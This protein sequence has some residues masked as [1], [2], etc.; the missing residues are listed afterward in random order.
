MRREAM[1][2]FSEDA[3]QVYSMVDVPRKAGLDLVGWSRPTSHLPFLLGQVTVGTSVAL[4]LAR[5]GVPILREQR[6]PTA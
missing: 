5:S 3:G 1:D 2:H 6:R 4:R